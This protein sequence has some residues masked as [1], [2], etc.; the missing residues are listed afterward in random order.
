MV[1]PP[2]DGCPTS[3]LE[4]SIYETPPHQDT[5]SSSSSSSSDDSLQIFPLHLPSVHQLAFEDRLNQLLEQHD[6][7]PDDAGNCSPFPSSLPNSPS[8]PWQIL[9]SSPQRSLSYSD[10]L[11]AVVPPVYANALLPL[12]PLNLPLLYPPCPNIM[13]PDPD[14]HKAKEVTPPTLA[15]VDPIKWVT[16]S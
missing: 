3:Q 15:D 1:H 13:A 16:F 2:Q 14:P 8:L 11:N 12:P 9:L 4:V 5:S 6:G 7:P 10:G